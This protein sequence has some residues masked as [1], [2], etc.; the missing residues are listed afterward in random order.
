MVTNLSSRSAFFT[1][2]QIVTIRHTKF[3]FII[4]CPLSQRSP[5][6]PIYL[7][8]IQICIMDTLFIIGTF[9]IDNSKFSLGCTG[10]DV[11]KWPIRFHI[12]SIAERDSTRST[13]TC[14]C[15]YT[16]TY[17]DASLSLAFPR[18]HKWQRDEP[19]VKAKMMK[20]GK[21]MNGGKKRNSNIIDMSL[22]VY[23]PWID[24]VQPWR[25][26]RLIGWTNSYDKS[27]SRA[28]AL[29]GSWLSRHWPARAWRGGSPEG[30]KRPSFLRAET[31]AADGQ[32]EERAC[33]VAIN[34]N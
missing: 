1:A 7:K 10:P 33:N 24:R 26:C 8:A 30:P 17:S 5:S 13:C 23:L 29:L 28:D 32:V 15:K 20:R 12:P 3:S 31:P 34:N 14:T 25:L 16:Y 4:K 22:H 27:N 21:E 2:H 11:H 6:P 9:F 19:R 18:S